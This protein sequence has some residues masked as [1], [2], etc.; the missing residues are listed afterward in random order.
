MSTNSVYV[1]SVSISIAYFTFI[2]VTYALLPP[3]SFLTLS[4]EPLQFAILGIIFS[5]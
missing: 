4:R 2:L 5:S 1:N 3:I